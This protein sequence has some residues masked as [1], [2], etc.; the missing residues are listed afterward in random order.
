MKKAICWECGKTIGISV[1]NPPRQYCPDCKQKM[2]QRVQQ[3]TA[4]WLRVSCRHLVDEALEQLEDAGAEVY[5]YREAYDEVLKQVLAGPVRFSD[6]TSVK[7]ALVLAHSGI[8]FKM[9]NRCVFRR[10][11]FMLPKQK[12]VLLIERKKTE[13]TWL[14]L[15]HMLPCVSKDLDKEWVAVRIDGRELDEHQD[16][17]EYR[18]EQL[19]K[20]VVEKIE[21]ERRPGPV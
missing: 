13:T 9:L 12:I 4:V 8:E 15:D 10:A 7:T 16:D 18:L 21:A 17:F 5:G 6:V 14:P 11:D 19:R 3:E 1:E 2:M 20:R